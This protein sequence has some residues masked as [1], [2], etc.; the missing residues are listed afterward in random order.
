M[1]APKIG[2]TPHGKLTT[3]EISRTTRSLPKSFRSLCNDGFFRASS[4]I[5]FGDVVALA[6]QFTTILLLLLLL[7]H[8]VPDRRFGLGAVC[9]I[10]EL[11]VIRLIVLQINVQ[12]LEVSCRVL[13]H[14]LVA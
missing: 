5:I 14:V 6:Q 9:G 12:F 3:L 10:K 4:P 2:R 13:F 8:R 11:G 7:H 1:E